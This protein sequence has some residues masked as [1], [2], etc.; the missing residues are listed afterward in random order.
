MMQRVTHPQI[1]H[2]ESEVKIWIFTQARNQNTDSLSCNKE[3][4]KCIHT[5]RQQDM[6]DKGMVTDVSG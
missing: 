6:C 1:F 4:K 3:G 2:H 5:L